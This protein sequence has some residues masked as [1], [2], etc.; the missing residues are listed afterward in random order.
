MSGSKY[1][2]LESFIPFTQLSHVQP[3]TTNTTFVTSNPHHQQQQQQQQQEGEEEGYTVGSLDVQFVLFWILAITFIR[4]VV[5]R[6]VLQPLGKL[7]GATKGK[8]IRFGE[9]SWLV[10]YYV[11]FWSFGAYLMWNSPYR[12]D[13]TQL[14]QGYP[15]VPFKAIFKFYYLVQ[16]AFWFQQLFSLHLEKPR[17]DHQAMFLHHVSTIGLI[18]LSYCFYFLRVGNAVL[19]CMDF[20]DIFLSVFLSFIGVN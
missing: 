5:I 8:I 13:L 10:V 3:N 2:Q 15:H 6:Q 17:K 9:Q 19:V 1:F 20:A 12:F 4:A 7:M 18:S 16:L 14:W 11:V